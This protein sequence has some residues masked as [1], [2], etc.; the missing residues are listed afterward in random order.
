MNIRCWLVG[1]LRCNLNNSIW[2]ITFHPWS[3]LLSRHHVIEIIE[4][5]IKLC[6]VPPT[7]PLMSFRHHQHANLKL[8][9]SNDSLYIYSFD[10]VSNW[11][12]I[13]HVDNHYCM[14]ID[15]TIAEDLMISFYIYYSNMRVYRY[16]EN[17]FPVTVINV[18]LSI[19]QVTLRL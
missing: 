3:F 11:N 8:G 9:N 10:T 5:M 6:R 19:L 2:Y 14:Q 15:S 18:P 12:Y 13:V 1:N 17:F 7:N 16:I 4:C